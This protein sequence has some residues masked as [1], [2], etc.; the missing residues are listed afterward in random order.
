[1][2]PHEIDTLYRW[3]CTLPATAFLCLGPLVLAVLFQAAKDHCFPESSGYGCVLTIAAII[4]LVI[5]GSLH[6][7]PGENRTLPFYLLYIPVA[8]VATGY[9]ALFAR[10]AVNPTG[11]LCA[12][13]RHKWRGCRCQYFRCHA[14]R[15]EG[16]EWN[17]CVCCNC[18]ATR[19]EEHDW[20]IPCTCQKCNMTREDEH[21]VVNHVC[22]VCNKEFHEWKE[23]D[24]STIS[25]ECITPHDPYVNWGG[26]YDITESVSERCACGAERERTE[27]YRR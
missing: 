13:N 10:V 25:S 23:L 19:D 4:G 21:V 16:H 26:V 7:G 11:L 24:R 1:M 6:G 5:A 27:S 9:L 12:F 2:W 3:Y 15:N 14:K 17:G 8:A 18:P 20:S 22:Q